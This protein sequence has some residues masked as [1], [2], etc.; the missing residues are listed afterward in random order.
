MDPPPAPLNFSGWRPPRAA[1]VAG[2]R[3]GGGG[4]KREAVLEQ[5]WRECFD[6]HCKEAGRIFDG[7]LYE[8]PSKFF[9]VGIGL[10]WLSS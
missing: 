2:G 10:F 5:L 9:F 8:V 7:E 6:G 4:K 3:E 1:Y